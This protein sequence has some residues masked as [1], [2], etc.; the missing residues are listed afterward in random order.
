METIQYNRA[1][2]INAIPHEI[3]KLKKYRKYC[4]NKGW[5]SQ[6][7]ILKKRIEELECEFEE[8][9]ESYGKS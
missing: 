1:E 5:L 7:V 2:R 6:A 9:Y 3:T 4:E 8:L